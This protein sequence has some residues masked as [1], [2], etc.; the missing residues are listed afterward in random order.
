MAEICGYW[1]FGSAEKDEDGHR[2]YPIVWK[3]EL[4]DGEGPATALQTVTA[5]SPPGSAW[6][7]DNDSDPTAYATRKLTAAPEGDKKVRYYL[8]T[9]EFTSK[10][11]ET[12]RDGGVDGGGGSGGCNTDPG[13]PIDEPQKV[14]GSFTHKTEEATFDRFGNRL[15]YSSHEQ[16][17]GPQVEFDKAEHQI[18]V[19]QNVAILELALFAPM[20]NTLNDAPLWGLP[21]RCIKFSDAKWERHTVGQCEVYYTRTFTFDCS[22]RYWQNADDEWVL[23]S[24]FDRDVLDESNKVLWGHWDASTGDWVIDPWFG[25][26]DADPSDPAQF[27]QAVDRQ[28][29]PIRVILNG[30]GVPYRPAEMVTTNDCSEGEAP[31]SWVLSGFTATDGT[32]INLTL[33]HQG[34]CLWGGTDSSDSAT[35]GQLWA[36]T[37]QPDGSHWVLTHGKYGQA[38]WKWPMDTG[39]EPDPWENMG[40]N[41]LNNNSV[42]GPGSVTVKAVRPDKPGSIHI[43]KYGE[44]NLLALRVPTSF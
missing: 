25:A 31:A 14:S 28:G 22:V 41:T 3:V 27:I 35:I 32:P 18:T 4:A 17:R 19:T 20:V 21:R 2:T 16:I 1:R 38:Q 10:P 40:P 37:L 13:S 44:S 15:L 5:A 26:E 24:G 12:D 23:A 6:V 39:S 33:T 36:V 42:Q 8:V 30:H 29:N 9:Q 11:P 43:E 34:G 7:F